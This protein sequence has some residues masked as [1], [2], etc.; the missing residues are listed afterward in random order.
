[1]TVINIEAQSPL[2]EIVQRGEEFVISMAGRHVA[3]VMPY[4][5]PIAQPTLD[6]QLLAALDKYEKH[7]NIPTVTL[8]VDE[9]GHIIVD[10]GLKN[11]HPDIYDWVVNG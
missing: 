6:E 4:A 10:E 9:N 7:N 5:Q 1:M 3:R 2:A 8:E 11:Q